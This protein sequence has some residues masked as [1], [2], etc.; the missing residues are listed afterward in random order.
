MLD[1]VKRNIIS[2]LWQ[3]YSVNLLYLSTIQSNLQTQYQEQLALDHLALIDLPGPNSG[4]EVLSRLFAYLGYVTRGQGYLTEKQNNFRWLAEQ[5]ATPQL[6]TN[7]LPQIVVADFRREALAPAVLKIIDYYAAFS[8]ALDSERLSCLQERVLQHD[9]VAA[10]EM[11][12]LIMSYLNRRDWPLPTVTEYETVKSHNELLAWVL[13]RG[14]Q[15]NHFAWAIHLSNYF[16]SLDAFNGFLRSSLNIPLNEKGGL[17]KGHAAQ[18]IEQ[19]ATL[20]ATESVK[21]ADGVIDLADRFIEFVWRYPKQAG[22]S[23]L[24]E[25]YFTGFIAD[26]ANRVVESLFLT[27][28]WERN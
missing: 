4:I 23:I 25:D 27:P 1:Y 6:A 7:A 20:A 28:T 11:I 14:R 26:N 21:L 24:W 22:I 10:Q 5:S 18:G 16:S 9:E 13:V 19:S 17:I 8:Q 2:Q 3:T 15:V 12:A